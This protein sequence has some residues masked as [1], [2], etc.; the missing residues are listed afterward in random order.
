MFPLS[1]VTDTP[2]LHFYTERSYR[3]AEVSNRRHIITERSFQH[4]CVLIVWLEFSQCSCTAKLM[5]GFSRVR[6]GMW[7]LLDSGLDDALLIC[8]EKTVYHGAISPQS[9]L[10]ILW[11]YHNFIVRVHRGNMLGNFRVTYDLWCCWYSWYVAVAVIRRAPHFS[12]PP[13]NVEVMPGGSVNLTCVAVG[14]PMPYVR[15]RLGSQELT[16]PEL[17]GRSVLVLTNIQE[18]LTY[19]CVA[20]NEMGIIENSTNVTV[21]GISIWWCFVRWL[22]CFRFFFP[23]FILWVTFGFCAMIVILLL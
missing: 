23:Y 6:K 3:P 15:W 14:S 1:P 7:V 11:I 17:I 12:F 4:K 22:V 9:L 8:I 13:E 20:A 5:L 21:K 16:P 2:I 18:S 19:T 10:L